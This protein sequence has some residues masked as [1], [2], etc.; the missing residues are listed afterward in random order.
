ME[1]EVDRLKK[2]L[3]THPEN[4]TSQV[5][6]RGDR[7]TADAVN[8][9]NHYQAHERIADDEAA[10]ARIAD[11]IY[12]ICVDCG[13]EIPDERLVVIPYASRC[14][15]CQGKKGVRVK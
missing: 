3:D 14:T 2:W 13:G 11:S 1:D 8:K 10:L 12:G 7:F 5:F 9:H 15:P 6:E 4:L